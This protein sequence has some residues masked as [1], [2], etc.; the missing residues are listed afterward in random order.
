MTYKN[1]INPEGKMNKILVVDDERS[2]RALY[3]VELSE[4][5]YKV[6][7]LGDGSKLLKVIE[8]KRPD[9]IVLD[10]QLGKYNG[11]DLLKDIRNRN[12]SMPVVLCTAYP[13]IKYDL[14]LSFDEYYVVKSIDLN[15]MKLK[16]RMALESIDEFFAEVELQCSRQIKRLRKRTKFLNWTKSQCQGLSGMTTPEAVFDELVK[17][18]LIRESEAGITYKLE[19]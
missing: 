18:Q 2:I 16:I 11:L 5:G 10:I 1:G 13:D 9:L 17:A 15:E 6:I 19:R 7:T 14:S 12:Y 8:Q 4:E 3:K